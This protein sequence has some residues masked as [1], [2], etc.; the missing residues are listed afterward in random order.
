MQSTTW[1]R[2]AVNPDNSYGLSRS[3]YNVLQ[4]QDGVGRGV[5]HAPQ[6][7]LTRSYG[8]HGWRVCRERNGH[9]VQRQI[10][11]G[12]A[13]IIL[14]RHRDQ[15][16]AQHEGLLGQTGQGRVRLLYTLHDDGASCA[17]LHLPFTEAM[18]V[19]VVPVQAGWFVGR[20]LDGVVE[21]LTGL[22]QRVHHLVRVAAGA[23]VEAVKMQV[24]D[25]RTHSAAGA[26]RVG[27]GIR[28]GF[29]RHSHGAH[30]V[31][32]RAGCMPHGG[33]AAGRTRGRDLRKHRT[34][35]CG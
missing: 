9:V 12:H 24:A 35:C 34:Q 5:E 2:H 3:A 25:R 8:H 33:H 17:A 29:A 13:R 15:Q 20:D 18:R 11:G 16:I 31:C 4:V 27:R 21:F 19:R 30:G 28:L 1:Y 23:Y 22:H 7:A 14:L 26:R 10:P 6:L 32:A